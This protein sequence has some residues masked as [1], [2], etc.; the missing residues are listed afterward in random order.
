M[1]IAF[2]SE[3]RLQYYKRNKNL[4]EKT[5]QMPAK[6][7]QIQNSLNSI[8]NYSLE[9]RHGT[10]LAISHAYYRKIKQSGIVEKNSNFKV[11]VLL[12]CSFLTN[13]QSLLVSAACKGIALIG[14]VTS[15]P[16]ADGDDTNAAPVQPSANDDESMQIDNV[17]DGQVTKL[18][19][20]NIL[21]QLLKSAHSR[22]RVREEAAECL[23]HLA[24]GDGRFFTTRN[25]DS[26]LKLLK[27]V[28][29]FKLISQF[30]TGS[31]LGDVY[32]SADERCF[33]EYCHRTGN[34][35]HNS[36]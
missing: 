27:L 31:Q 19:V 24:I 10:L 30:C 34:C 7:F 20:M 11:V 21:L 12:L 32:L 13:Q 6:R 16:L 25:L 15:L 29:K 14:S 23:G 28:S 17:D 22:P 36:R 8:G 35:R 33:A 5:H 18:Q 1:N 9:H 3:P 26:F 2:V 4:L